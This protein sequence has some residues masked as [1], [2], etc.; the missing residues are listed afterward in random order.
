MENPRNV[1]CVGVGRESWEEGREGVFAFVIK[2]GGLC[3]IFGVVAFT[4]H[5]CLTYFAQLIF[6]PLRYVSQKVTQVVRPIKGDQKSK[7]SDRPKV[8]KIETYQ[9]D[10]R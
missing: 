3:M 10:Q 5:K 7:V 2:Y 9:T 4:Y 1:R 8:T 6:F